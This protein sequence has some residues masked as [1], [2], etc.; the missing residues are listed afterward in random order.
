MIV[1]RKL[2]AN[3]VISIIRNSV[4]LSLRLKVLNIRYEKPSGSTRC[5][6]YV[7]VRVL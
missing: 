2:E 1:A 4:T 5:V 7:F 6:S 3:I